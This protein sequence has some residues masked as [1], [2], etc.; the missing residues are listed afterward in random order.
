[1]IAGNNQL[2]HDA[3]DIED[4]LYFLSNFEN[5]QNELRGQGRL[6]LLEQFF[7]SI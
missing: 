7:Y 6:I 1:M 3:V 5:I 4:P 2:F